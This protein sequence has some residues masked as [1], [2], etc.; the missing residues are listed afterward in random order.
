MRSAPSRNCRRPRA[1]S[2]AVWPPS[3]SVRSSSSGTRSGSP[4]AAT[5]D[6]A[7]R[8]RSSA[9]AS[10]ASSVCA[11]SRIVVEEGHGGD[12]ARNVLVDA[13]GE[14]SLVERVHILRAGPPQAAEGRRERRAVDEARRA[15]RVVVDPEV[16]DRSS[17]PLGVSP[18]TT[19]IP[20]ASR[21]RKSPPARLRSLEPGQQAFRERPLAAEKASASASTTARAEHVALRREVVAADR[22][23]GRDAGGA[24][25][26]AV[27]GRVDDA[28]CRKSRSSSAAV[29]RASAA[30]ARPLAQQ[31][32]RERAVASQRERLRRHRTNAGRCPRNGRS[33]AERATLNADAELPV[34]GVSR[35]QRVG[36]SRGCAQRGLVGALRGLVLLERL[37]RVHVA[38]HRMIRDERLGRRRRRIAARAP[39]RAPSPSSR[40]SPAGPRSAASGRRRRPHPARRAPRRRRTPLR[41]PPRA[42]GRA[43]PCCRES[44]GRRLLAEDRVEPLGSSAAISRRVE[45]A[46]PLLQLQRAA[47]GGRDGHLLVEDEADQ[48]RERVARD[49]LVRLADR[50]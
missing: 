43:S 26:T 41:R 49:Q 39:R 31:L 42:P 29:S 8:H 14:C 46:E 9:A 44:G 1:T 5:A 28:T 10:G 16:D 25:V 17:D 7:T 37:R 24:R 21:P 11:R 4:S 45:A 13:R 34:A 33:G 32:E 6:R 50:R 12:P 30:P 48:E 38:E 27:L 35:D 20:P 22:G 18:A 36:R 19:R 23:C 3:R 15:D 40:R 47:E 2:S